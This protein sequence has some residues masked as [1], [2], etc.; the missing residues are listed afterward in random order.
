MKKWVKILVAMVLILLVVVGI[1]LNC[2]VSVFERMEIKEAW[3]ELEDH[4][5]LRQVYKDRVD[6]NR[7]YILDFRCYGT[8]NGYTV[9]YLRTDLS[10]YGEVIV[11]G[12]VFKHPSSYRF[13]AYKD[14]EFHD[15]YDVCEDGGISA[16]QI[17][18]I[19]KIHRN[20][21]WPY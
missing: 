15:F 9:L 5:Y 21:P 14:G 10:V 1:W 2:P 6:W 8:Y 11:S 16:N 13:Y 3:F 18:Q 20:W 12:E 7:C 19:A 4:G 17:S